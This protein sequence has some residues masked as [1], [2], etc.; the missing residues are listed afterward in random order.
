MRYV[1]AIAVLMI[2]APP[3]V[4]DAPAASSTQLREELADVQRL[5]IRVQRQLDELKAQTDAVRAAAEAAPPATPAPPAD[6]LAQVETDQ[7]RIIERLDRIA[8]RLDQLENRTNPV[9]SPDFGRSTVNLNTSNSIQPPLTPAPSYSVGIPSV[10]AGFGQVHYVM[11]WPA[12]SSPLYYPDRR[13]CGWYSPTPWRYH[14]DRRADH[15]WGLRVG[16]N[17]W[18]GW[19]N[20]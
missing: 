19:V 6:P 7:R 3:C 15:G 11:R 20:W 12:R 18:S 1:C 4:A 9:A 8:A 14:H 5:L 2:A 16:N 13:D 10:S 17:G